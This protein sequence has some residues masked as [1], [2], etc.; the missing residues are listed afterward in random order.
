MPGGPTPAAL[1]ERGQVHALYWMAHSRAVDAP[2]AAAAANLE[3]RQPSPAVPIAGNSQC[4]SPAES[5][6]VATTAALPPLGANIAGR[7]GSSGGIARSDKRV[8]C[9]RAATIQ[10]PSRQAQKEQ[11][12]K[13]AAARDGRPLCGRTMTYWDRLHAA[14][15][16][17]AGAAAR[18]SG[19]VAE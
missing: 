4:N 7:V 10:P 13:A 12:L 3:R 11:A 8:E 17:A 15:R 19:L 16:L 14:T 6:E 2:A 5:H 1:K 18:P 9:R